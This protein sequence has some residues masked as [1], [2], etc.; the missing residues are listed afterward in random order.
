MNINN[1]IM[2]NT[3]FIA[4][5]LLFGLYIVYTYVCVLLL[6]DGKQNKSKSNQD[7]ANTTSNTNAAYKK[8]I[9]GLSGMP[10]SIKPESDSPHGLFEIGP[11]QEIPGI[12]S[13]KVLQSIKKHYDE[14]PTPNQ[15]DPTTLPIVDRYLQKRGKPLR[16]LTHGRWW[17]FFL[18]DLKTYKLP[19]GS[20]Q[21]VPSDQYFLEWVRLLDIA[22]D[23]FMNTLKLNFLGNGPPTQKLYIYFTATGMGGAPDAFTGSNDSPYGAR[24]AIFNFG[25]IMHE[26][27]HA[28]FPRTPDDKALRIK[29]C[30]DPI[31]S[32]KEKPYYHGMMIGESLM[33]NFFGWYCFLS[34]ITADKDN[35]ELSVYHDATTFTLLGL[36]SN[37][38]QLAF[39]ATFY[40]FPLWKPENDGI[41]DGSRDKYGVETFSYVVSMPLLQK[42]EKKY[43][44]R[45]ET[46]YISGYLYLK[47][48]VKMMVALMYNLY[49]YPCILKTI[50]FLLGGDTTPH[51]F[52]IEY[53]IDYVLQAYTTGKSR[54][55]NGVKTRTKLPYEFCKN[56]IV[57]KSNANSLNSTDPLEWKGFEVYNIRNFHKDVETVK[58]IYIEFNVN[59][60]SD[61][62]R[63]AFVQG[64]PVNGYYER[65][66]ESDPLSKREPLKSPGFAGVV[67]KRYSIINGQ[68]MS[69]TL[70][71]DAPAYV[72]LVA[73]G[74]THTDVMPGYTMKVRLSQAGDV[75]SS[76]NVTPG[77][78]PEEVITVPPIKGFSTVGSKDPDSCPTGTTSTEVPSSQCIQDIW[79]S[80]GCTAPVPST[81][82]KT[83]GDAMHGFS[84]I[85]V[86]NQAACF[87][88]PNVC[89]GVGVDAIPNKECIRYLWA[90]GGCSRPIPESIYPLESP[91]FNPGMNMYSSRPRSWIE[92]GISDMLMCSNIKNPCYEPSRASSCIVGHEQNIRPKYG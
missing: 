34:M 19:G 20:E 42:I 4:F 43:A 33:G 8:P 89:D 90:K 46:G 40:L 51:D 58:T 7:V 10:G 22:A 26:M 16:Q 83:K 6:F 80:Y 36:I 12:Y 62:W 24:T 41:A 75:V 53:A 47:Y 49:R 9:S 28:C 81:Q 72:I 61:E 74:V 38:A 73:G 17:V 21:T 35:A 2:K 92:R 68:Q 14:I 50:C 15:I 3:V 13:A 54:E 78:R 65:R 82:Y 30:G 55:Y 23:K 25:A 57:T 84:K 5:S 44:S 91:G 85:V 86:E 37:R 71:G 45:Y 66:L 60:Y 88:R 27:G 1:M 76:F 52:M 59:A 77:P 32:Y 39:D 11:S 48:G 70:S 64:W 29:C 18:G 63:V 87:G 67:N 69:F 31:V 79:K 56:R